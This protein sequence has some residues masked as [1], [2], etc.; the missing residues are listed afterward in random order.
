MRGSG[1]SGEIGAHHRVFTGG[2]CGRS[3]SP[4]GGDCAAQKER[5]SD[6]QRHAHRV[7]F[8]TFPELAATMRGPWS[9]RFAYPG[10]LS[11]R[12]SRI[13][14]FQYLTVSICC[15]LVRTVLLAGSV[16]LPPNMTGWISKISLLA[17]SGG[18]LLRISAGLGIVM[19]PS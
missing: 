19:Y 16:G 11:F 4:T 7:R 5:I 8:G 12:I 15:C 9:R 18:R 6:L 14:L 2:Y 17:R 13:T 10:A 3:S 1:L